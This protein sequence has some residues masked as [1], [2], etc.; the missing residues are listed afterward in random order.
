MPTQLL[1]LFLLWGVRK[2]LL[3]PSLQQDRFDLGWL[4]RDISRELRLLPEKT[5]Q[6]VLSAVAALQPAPGRGE[7][8]KEEDEEAASGCY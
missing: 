5:R 4:L 1:P 8:V 3:E 6:G 2:V 7:Q